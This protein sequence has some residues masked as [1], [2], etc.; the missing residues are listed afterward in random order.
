MQ[1]V[2]S[3]Y[4]ES[5]ISQEFFFSFWADLSWQKLH[6]NC[7]FSSWT[8]QF[9]ALKCFFHKLIYW[10]EVCMFLRSQWDWKPFQPCFFHEL[11]QYVGLICNLIFF[12][13]GWL[14]DFWNL[15]HSTYPICFLRRPKNLTKSSPSIWHLLKTYS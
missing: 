2:F 3:L 6:R 9:I 1:Y 10:V 12:F 4:L 14:R 11:M 5:H 13:A 15:N 8:D 7:F